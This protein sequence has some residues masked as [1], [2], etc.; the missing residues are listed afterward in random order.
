VKDDT[1]LSLGQLMELAQNGDRA[2]FHA[3]FK[4]IDALITRSLR[5][6]FPHNSDIEDIYQE[7]LLAVYKSRHTYQPSQPL[8]PWLFATVR[9]VS[10]EHFR[11]HRQRL[12]F[13]VPVDEI[14]EIHVEGTS[15]ADL[16]LRDALD[17]LSPGQIEAL[18]LTKVLGLSVAE[19]A[20]RANTTV[21]SM[22]VRVHRAYEI[23]K[24]VATRLRTC[25][26]SPKSTTRR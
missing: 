24:E 1:S 17:Q 16:E 5:R 10:S 2:A 25:R 20:R 18:R 11:R 9:K 15:S 19:A 26:Q 12:G 6:R 8:E 7:V 21:G 14:P 22:R 3:L 13:Q 4:Q 23:L